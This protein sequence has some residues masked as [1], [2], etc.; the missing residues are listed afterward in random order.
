MEGD[1]TEGLPKGDA[2]A[3][4][5]PSANSSFPSPSIREAAPTR[6]GM[7]ARKWETGKGKIRGISL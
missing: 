7:E 3:L 2:R 1:R 4:P 5:S 6:R